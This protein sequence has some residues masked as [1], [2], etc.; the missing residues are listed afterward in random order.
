MHITN[1]MLKAR[2]REDLEVVDTS[3]M[4][5]YSVL[6]DP[7]TG[8]EYSCNPD[9]YAHLLRDKETGHYA[10]ISWENAYHPEF[11]LSEVE[12]TEVLVA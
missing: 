6:F 9:D 3:I 10:A 8:S 4:A 5:D 12:A 7:E 1:D 2:G 11:L